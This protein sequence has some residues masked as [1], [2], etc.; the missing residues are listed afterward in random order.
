MEATFTEQGRETIFY[1]NSNPKQFMEIMNIR[2]LLQA[3]SSIEHRARPVYHY[4]TVTTL[5]CQS[6]SNNMQA[7]MSGGIIRNYSSQPL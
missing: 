1:E 2:M 6:N 7:E 5:V 3:E 4:K